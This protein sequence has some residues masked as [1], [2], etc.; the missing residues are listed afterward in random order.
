MFV[1]V[2]IAFEYSRPIQNAEQ[3]EGIVRRLGAFLQIGRI[4]SLRFSVAICAKATLFRFN[5]R[6]IVSNPP[7]F[8]VTS[9]GRP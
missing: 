8:P 4:G 9:I 6:A 7:V 3:F 5:A 1:G 2:P